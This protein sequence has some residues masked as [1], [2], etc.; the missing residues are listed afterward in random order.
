MIKRFAVLLVLT[1]AALGLS[2]SGCDSDSDRDRDSHA[3]H[4]HSGGCCPSD[5]PAPTPQVVA[6]ML[7]AD[8]FVGQ[9]HQEAEDIA[10]VLATAKGGDVVTLRGIIGGSKEP[11]LPNHA[12]MFLVDPSVPQCSAEG[13]SACSTPW[14]YCQ[15]SAE[16][17]QGKVVMVA[18]LGPDGSPLPVPFSDALVVA[19]GRLVTVQGRLHIVGEGKKAVQAATIYVQPDQAVSTR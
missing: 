7:P 17:L 11:I 9:P 3:S 18:V 1:V 16:E 6:P 19:P 10:A 8:L 2:I 13:D 4:S 14:D 15:R 5:S 12:S